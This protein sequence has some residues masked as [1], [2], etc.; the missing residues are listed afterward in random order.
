MVSREY[1]ANDLKLIIFCGL[2]LPKSKV[3]LP[4]FD[5]LN[6]QSLLIPCLGNKYKGRL[7]LNSEK[8]FMFEKDNT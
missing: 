8:M 2:P 7:Y 4:H 3:V 1:Y 6:W 5:K